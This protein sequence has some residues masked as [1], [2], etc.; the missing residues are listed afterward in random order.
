MLNSA[1]TIDSINSLVKKE[2]PFLFIISFDGNSNVVFPLDK[3][4][5]KNIF[6]KTPSA[7]NLKNDNFNFQ[8]EFFNKEPMPFSD[9][10]AIFQ[11]VKGEIGKGN[12]F[13]LNLTASTPIESNL[14]LYGLFSIAQAKYKLFYNNEFALFSPECFIKIEESR[15]KTFPM[16]GTIRADIPDARE[17]LLNDGKE[18]AEHATIVDL[19]R[20]DLS[21]V[22]TNVH[23][24][25]YKY[26][27]LIE[28]NSGAIYQMSSEIEGELPSDFKNRLGEILFSLLPA[29]SVTGAPK[30]KTVEIIREVE[31][32]P[33]GYYT[34]VFGVWDNEKLDSAV[35]IRFIRNDAGKLRYH[36]GGGITFQ[37]DCKLEYNEMIEKIYVPIC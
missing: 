8:L 2:I 15:I 22:A 14:N 35:M 29:G 28:T 21:R 4:H 32:Q 11:K 16:K 33:R 19:L 25:R 27:D 37:S 3:L 12:T 31:M 7:N 18:T 23:L 1:E 5:S 10:S 13:L 34:G 17:R 20:N 26:L 30:D 6:F 24:N 36:S 9:Y